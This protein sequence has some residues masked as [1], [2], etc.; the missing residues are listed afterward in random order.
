MHPGTRREPLAWTGL[1]AASLLL[2][3]WGLGER[4]MSHD[5]SLHAVY[6]W[7]FSSKGTYAYD[8]MMHGPLLFHLNALVYR[9]LGVSDFSARLVPALA[10]VG[11][12]AM[13][14]LYRRWLGRG[15]AFA[16]ALLVAVSPDL[17]YYSRYIR[18]DIYICLST[19]L[20][21]WAVARYREAQQP[22]HLVWLALGLGLSFSCKEVCYIH[23]TMLGAFCV[24]G[25]AGALWRRRSPEASLVPAALLLL[26]A[27]P[28]ASAL[29]HPLL[30][31]FPLD[32]RGNE[33]VSPRIGW[34]AGGGFLL[35]AA[36]GAALA[37]WRGL[38]AVWARAFGVFW[39]IT[40]LLY[41]SCFTRPEGVIR[42]LVGGLGYWLAQHEVKRGTDDPL[43]YVSLLLLYVPLLLAAAG[44]SLWK[45]RPRGITPLLVCWFAVHLAVYSWAGEKMP[46]L[47]THV[48]LPLCVLSG[49]FL[50]RLC[51]P[52]ASRWA[53]AAFAL[54]ALQFLA[55]SARLNGRL[56]ESYFEPL[57]YAHAGPHLKAALDIVREELAADPSAHVQVQSAFHWPLV[58][59]FRGQRVIYSDSLAPPDPAAD[60]LIAPVAEREALRAQGW[61]PR[62]EVDM[63]TWPRQ[64]WHR[65]HRSNL[66]RLAENPT[67]RRRFLRYYLFR[68]QPLLAPG[69]WPPPNRFLLLSRPEDGAQG[70]EG[71]P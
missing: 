55:N 64:H 59:Y 66:A 22:R 54:L 9:I 8:P 4:G 70:P 14:R 56:A 51:R 27:L 49:P 1:L 69:E 63:I 44:G 3:L 16:A 13:L 41:S 21:V 26:L 58:W 47:L 6:S 23:G 10:G 34:L 7:Y 30:G 43:L 35:A 60:V 20:M 5:E 71:S 15:G 42:G 38:L 17:L 45:A 39:G 40:L 61:T 19:L 28:F 37:A 33:G 46:W 31:W 65:I 52:D 25:G 12:V 18:N 11:C 32:Y 53:R 29:L 48:T 36:V 24:A 57:T 67:V 50:A 68:D 2:R 62:L